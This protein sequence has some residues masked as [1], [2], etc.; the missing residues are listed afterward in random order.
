MNRLHEK[1]ILVGR[2]PLND[3]LLIAVNGSTKVA[4]VACTVPPTVS[5]C[6]PE[7]AAAHLNLYVDAQGN[8]K[9]TNV[10]A[11]NC[12]FVNGIA[13]KTIAVKS[14]DVVELGQDHFRVGVQQ[15]LNAA[16]SVLPKPV[17]QYN[18]F[19]LHRVWNDYKDGLKDIQNKRNKMAMQQRMPMMFSM[20]GGIL[21]ASLGLVWPQ[22][23]QYGFIVSAIGFILM[24]Y[25][26]FRNPVQDINDEKET[27]DRKLENLY[28][29]PNPNCGKSLPAKDLNYIK[30]QFDMHC[31]YCKC[32]YI[33]KPM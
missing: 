10:K 8:I 19:H 25:F 15:I 12:T 22:M 21:G 3:G 30:R 29:C 1:T 13:I 4:K 14:S 27:L 33:D 9:A 31:P 11:Q 23:Q 6:Q 2:S 26:M 18:I 24:F 16:T 17:Q 32:Q 5:R 28:V 7:V 20:G